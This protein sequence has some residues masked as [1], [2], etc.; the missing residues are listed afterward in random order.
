MRKLRH[1]D[2]VMCPTVLKG[3]KWQSNSTPYPVLPSLHHTHAWIIH[4]PCN[5][6]EAPFWIAGILTHLGLW[7]SFPWLM[8]FLQ[9][10][11]GRTYKPAS[12]DAWQSLGFPCVNKQIYF[13]L[14]Y[15]PCPF[16]PLCH[17]LWLRRW[18]PPFE[19]LPERKHHCTLIWK[20]QRLII[21]ISSQGWEG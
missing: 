1:R 3:Q 6:R 5:P 2:S 15:F 18:K 21:F 14:L 11:L 10:Y 12:G 16:L 8:C 13:S 17:R 7:V 4:Y 19:S 20:D 9:C